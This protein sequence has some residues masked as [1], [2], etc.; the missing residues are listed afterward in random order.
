MTPG[1]N[2]HLYNYLSMTIGSWNS[3]Y[4]TTNSRYRPATR[5]MIEAVNSVSKGYFTS[6][7]LDPVFI[8]RSCTVIHSIQVLEVYRS[9]LEYRSYSRNRRFGGLPIVLAT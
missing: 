6:A 3:M 9:C 1:S 7:I 4:A 2:G 5:F 8:D